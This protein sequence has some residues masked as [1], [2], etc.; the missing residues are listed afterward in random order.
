MKLIIPE[1]HIED[2]RCVYPWPDI[3]AEAP[4]LSD[5]AIVMGRMWRLQNAKSI[6]VVD[7]NRSADQ[8]DSTNEPVIHALCDRLD[9]PVQVDCGSSAQPLVSEMIAM[10]AYRV[11]LTLDHIDDTDSVCQLIELV[12]SRKLS[13]RLP[14]LTEENSADL[15]NT[16]SCLASAKCSRVLVT[17]EDRLTKQ[18]ES[19][20]TILQRIAMIRAAA[21]SRSLAITIER[22]VELFEDLA[23]LDSLTEFGVDSVL[24]GKPL[25]ANSFPCQSFWIWNEPGE[26][27]LD[28]FSSA[29]MR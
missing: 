27:D 7:R 24:I 15:T 14:A 26:V 2:G 28:Q 3:D 9:I 8:H 6:V 13:I 10:G 20:T 5:D 29:S 18:P 25:Y 1:L 23:V 4:N 22:G 21:T 11:I 16:L 17:A 12:G 19:L